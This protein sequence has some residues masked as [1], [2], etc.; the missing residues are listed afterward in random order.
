MESVFFK[1]L[2][3]SEQILQAVA[4][5]GFEEATPIQASAIPPVMEGRDVIGQALTGTGKTSA[6]G[7]PAIEKVDT[8]GSAIQVLILCPTRELA[9]QVSEEL[10]LLSK[11]KSDVNILPVYGGQPIERQ[12]IG[13]RKRPQIVIGTPGRVMDHMRRKTIKLSSL[14]MLVLDEADEML[15]MGFRE[16]IDTILQEAPSERQ[17]LLFSATMPRPI[18]E[19]T[20]LYQ[21][22]PL[23]IA[24]SRQE[25]TVPKIEQY[26]LEVRDHARL[27]VLSRLIDANNL[28]LCLVFCNTKKRVDELSL[29]LQAR[30]YSAEALHGDMK[31]TE[32]DKVMHRFRTGQINVLI[33]TDVAAR[34]IDVDDIE[35]VFN[36]DLPQ[37]QE[38][39][40]HRIGRTGR[41][42]KSGRAYTFVAGHEI[43][44]LRQ[45][46]QFAKTHIKLLRPPTLTDVEAGRM[47]QVM[48][49]LKSAIEAGGYAE[50][51]SYIEK[52]LEE[53]N[54]VTEGEGDLTTLDI[55]A[56]LLKLV[57]GPA[58][59]DANMELDIDRGIFEPTKLEDRGAMARM[60][61][62]VGRMDRIQPGNIVSSIATRAGIPGK[63]IGSIEIYDKCT[64][65]EV[66]R[67]Y[68]RKVQDAMNNFTLKGRRIR[69]HE[70]EGRPARSYKR[71]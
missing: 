26:Y 35:A 31:Q 18:L 21:K 53:M 1:D 37:D 60:F 34:G 48:D 39:Y 17:T 54:A 32:R 55:A 63:V 16:D 70:D 13:L 65:V 64:F 9:I 14:R 19:L 51:T 22:D 66:P 46:Q 52:A 25:V 50:Y 2:G 58:M 42:G 49:K 8:E 36:Y 44:D 12:F 27:E 57:A 20:K 11:Y 24:T 68:V 4:D 41:A 62:N 43:Y 47:G 5:M 38:Y 10:R 61:I 71:R 29:G 67:E 3:L 15:N 23:H 33:A 28:H 45:I 7:I 59:T 56:A 69:M 40:V 30:G 6:F